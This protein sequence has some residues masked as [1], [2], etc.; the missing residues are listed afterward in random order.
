MS[1]SDRM[2]I[3][4]RILSNIHE[5]MVESDETR[6]KK[7]MKTIK[8][9]SAQYFKPEHLQIMRIDNDVDFL[10]RIEHFALEFL[11]LYI[12]NLPSHL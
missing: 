3:L 11:E 12:V 2:Y 4:V 1:Q 9:L 7:L 8:E 5:Y 10:G 6:R